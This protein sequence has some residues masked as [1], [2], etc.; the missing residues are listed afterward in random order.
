MRK[1][2]LFFMALMT[3]S[4]CA[5]EVSHEFNLGEGTQFAP[6]DD[7][8]GTYDA[9]TKT[10]R[11]N[12]NGAGQL[13]IDA[14][15]AAKYEQLILEM[16]SVST[17][18][19]KITVEFHGSGLQE[20]IIPVGKT[21]G[22]IELN[23][24]SLKKIE[25][26]NNSGVAATF[27]FS[28]L[29]L[30]GQS[31]KKF[32]EVLDN[33]AH[34][35]GDWDWAN[36]CNIA[37]NKF[38]NVHAGAKLVINY[39]TNTSTTDKWYQLQTKS[40]DVTLAGNDY[41][42]DNGTLNVSASDTS[43]TITLSAAD[44]ATLKTNGLAIEGHEVTISSVELNY[45]DENIEV[46]WEGE[47]TVGN[48]GTLVTLE[49]TFF[50]NAKAGDKVVC[51]VTPEAGAQAQIK[52]TTGDNWSWVDLIPCRDISEANYE[53]MLTQDMIDAI[54]AGHQIHFQGKNHTITAIELHAYTGPSVIWSDSQVFDANWSNNVQIAKEAFAGMQ[55]GYRLALSV[56]GM[57]EGQCINIQ[58]GSWH[59]FPHNMQYN[60]TAEDAEADSKVVEFEL[61]PRE[62]EIVLEK[63][64]IVKG[65]S[66]TLSKVKVIPNVPT[67]TTMYHDVA[68]SEAGMATLLLPFD[69]TLP[70]GMKA[71]KLTVNNNNQIVAENVESITADQPVLLVA[72]KG[73]Y[74]LVSAE[75]VSDALSGKDATYPH[76]DLVGTYQNYTVSAST[77]PTYNYVLQNNNNCVGFYQVTSDG[78]IAPYRAYLTCGYDNSAATLAPLR[79]VFQDQTATATE[80][81]SVDNKATKV[82]RDGQLYILHNNQLYTIQGQKIQ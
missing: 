36:R 48:W 18:P 10:F 37:A 77:A 16:A 42:L 8:N 79:I 1:I 74:T 60:F 15:D 25:L 44:A 9:Y 20:Y 51:C 58:D 70:D 45:W 47:Q 46:L 56:S 72:D 23:Q 32:T 78:T 28:S 73:N 19:M 43:T 24:H 34:N 33:T 35:L 66:Y 5:K 68:I 75:G 49:K 59:N 11:A 57:T 41:L 62:L 61:S 13:W 30:V 67:L 69:A 29:R 26:K 14:F 31:G 27:V 82:L 17:Q 6:Y 63:G 38:A 64:I 22:V 12:A 21:K 71:Y 2:F 80:N 81:L 53:V 39:T 55:L 76:G 50:E 54:V 52:Y 65:T 3:M 4:L 40:N 7:G